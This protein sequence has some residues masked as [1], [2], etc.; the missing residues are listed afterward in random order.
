[1]IEVLCFFGCGH[2]TIKPEHEIFC[3]KAAPLESKCGGLG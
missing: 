1:M 2:C 3:C